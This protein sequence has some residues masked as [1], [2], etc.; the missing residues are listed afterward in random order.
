M[1]DS[2]DQMPA[3]VKIEGELV[4]PTSL[5]AFLTQMGRAVTFTNPI[6]CYVKETWTRTHQMIKASPY[7]ASKASVWHNKKY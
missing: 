6:L 3:W 2:L 7:V 1:N 4:A 5:E